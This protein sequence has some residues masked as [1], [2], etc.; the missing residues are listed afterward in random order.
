MVLDR[1]LAINPGSHRTGDGR[2]CPPKNPHSAWMPCGSIL[3]N[4]T[5]PS[6]IGY[7]VVDVS[8]VVATH[9]SKILQDNAQE[10]FG[11][12]EAQEMLDRLARAFTQTG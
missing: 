4:M 6:R 2:D 8:T 7:T 5:R 11:H 3:C 1:E 9:L 12:Q 10:L